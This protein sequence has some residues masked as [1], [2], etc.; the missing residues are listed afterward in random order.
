MGNPESRE[1]AKISLAP[2]EK[3]KRRSRSVF[4][5]E[6]ALRVYEKEGINPPLTVDELR[7]NGR[8]KG[9]L[10]VPTEFVFS[11]RHLSLG[12]KAVWLAIFLHNWNPD[13]T[14]RVSWPGRER[15]A[16]IVGKSV[17]QVSTYLGGLRKKG[18]LKTKRRLD[19][20]SLYLLWD[21]PQRWMEETKK[22]LENENLKRRAKTERQQRL[23][24]IKAEGPCQVEWAENCRN[25]E[26][27]SCL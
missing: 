2:Q 20:T 25:E 19:R 18:L 7:Y 24:E 8:S 15:L 11:S 14:Y 17:R 26:E 16:L 5:R 1:G 22:E 3:G 27:E 23:K 6:L 10:V 12:E 4:R 13:P 21:P 9:F